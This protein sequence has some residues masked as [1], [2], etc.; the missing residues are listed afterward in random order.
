VIIDFIIAVFLHFIVESTNRCPDAV[1]QQAVSPAQLPIA[2]GRTAFSCRGEDGRVCHQD[3]RTDF[4][5]PAKPP[6][7]LTALEELC[8]AVVLSPEFAVV[9]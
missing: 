7:P 4:A 3:A 8:Q 9:E 2:S 6:V 1:R 5:D